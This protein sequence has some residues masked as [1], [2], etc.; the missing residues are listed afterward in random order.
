MKLPFGTSGT[1]ADTVRAHQLEIKNAMVAADMAHAAFGMSTGAASSPTVQPVT[2]NQWG[3]QQQAVEH[4]KTLELAAATEML[5]AHGADELIHFEPVHVL[6]V[7]RRRP[8]C[9]VKG[10]DGW[11]V[12]AR[13][14]E[15][16]NGQVT[17]TRKDGSSSVETIAEVV[18]S[19]Q[20]D[21]EW[22]G[23]LRMVQT[24][25]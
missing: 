10:Y 20:V 16:Q 11:Y 6:A 21:G 12:A 22:V 5:V 14:E 8:A 15:V 17:V 9:W 4:A 1:I 7:V 18:A 3:G 25:R 13:I 24:G 2:L 23:I 19:G